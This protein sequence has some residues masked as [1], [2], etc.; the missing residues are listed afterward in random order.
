METAV[1][2]SV[3]G[4]FVVFFPYLLNLKRAV[5]GLHPMRGWTDGRLATILEISPIFCLLLLLLEAA[6]TFSNGQNCSGI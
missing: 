2:H 4:L 5:G 3:H 1:T 6:E